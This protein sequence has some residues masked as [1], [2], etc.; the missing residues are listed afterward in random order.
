MSHEFVQ[1]K[2]TEH[3]TEDEIRSSYKD[4]LKQL[5]DAN[6]QIQPQF[7]TWFY[8]YKNNTVESEFKE[9][10]EKY[11]SVD[12]KE[13]KRFN[14]DDS[15][16]SDTT[17]FTYPTD[18][19]EFPNEQ[20][21]TEKDISKNKTDLSNTFKKLKLAIVKAEENHQKNSFVE[22]DKKF[23]K[24]DRVVEDKQYEEVVKIREQI[25]KENAEKSEQKTDTEK[26]IKKKTETVNEKKETVID[27]EEKIDLKEETTVPEKVIEVKEMP[28]SNILK[29]VSSF[30]Y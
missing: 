1:F 17:E 6:S 19:L 5:S 28:Q 3:A 21:K 8:I 27:K 9:I 18:E 12:V 26:I 15:S 25:N 20:T 13:I 23:S 24:F 30:F 10:I 29:Q 14:F 22:K 11:Y 2:W 4:S 16:E 7:K